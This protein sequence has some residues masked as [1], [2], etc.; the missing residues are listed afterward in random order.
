[1]NFQYRINRLFNVH[2]LWLI[3]LVIF[4]AYRLTALIYF[5]LNFTDSDQVVIWHSA[6][7]FAAGIFREPCYYG[8]AYNSNLEG[9]MAVP[10]VW[11]GIKPYIAVPLVSSLMAAFPFL[12]FSAV[13]KKE[14]KPLLASL[15]LWLTFLLPDS[16]TELSIMSR[17]FIQGIFCAVCGWYIFHKKPHPLRIISGSFLIAM[18][19]FQ[20]INAAMFV[21][22][23]L[24]IV[25]VEKHWWK[26]KN[27]LFF[28]SGSAVAYALKLLAERF[29]RLHP[30]KN[31]HYIPSFSGD[32]GYFKDHIGNLDFFLSQTF[33]KTPSPLLGFVFFI[34]AVLLLHKF[35]KKSL[36][37]C[38]VL[39]AL[40]MSSL[41]LAKLDNYSTSVFFGQGRFFLAMPY[42]LLF[43]VAS[44]PEPQLHAKVSKYLL[45]F[46]LLGGLLFCGEFKHNV[47]NDSSLRNDY[48]LAIQTIPELKKH[49]AALNDSLHKEH[50]DFVLVGNHWA[51]NLA[52][53][54]C[55]C[56]ED[57]FPFAIR[58][59]HE[60]RT[61]MADSAQAFRPGKL[62]L[63]HTDTMPSKLLDSFYRNHKTHIWG[64][65]WIVQTD[66]T[67]V[68]DFIKF[69]TTR[70][71]KH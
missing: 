7:D 11:A 3:S 25:V 38:F 26:L 47:D 34:L 66:T 71:L 33:P 19:V 6:K 36:I 14:Q 65:S 31:T 61:W 59:Q 29:Y 15:V 22:P 41:F 30:E 53:M 21:L 13:A 2:N 28:L 62:L 67:R 60:R 1:M 54:G 4:I 8:Q 10:L 58:A 68:R 24:S 35:G 40:F 49:C 50:I 42:A 63:M 27:L 17:G 20:N 70:I 45:P 52:S 48:T 55:T 5:G 69:Y 37:F 16:F 64:Q 57:S 56:M 12:L 44:A 32:P 46:S 23:L 51:Y 18:G 43:M 9:L 39:L